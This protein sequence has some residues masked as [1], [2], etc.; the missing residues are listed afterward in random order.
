MTHLENLESIRGSDVLN[1]FM[2][3]DKMGAE[4]STNGEMKNA[5]KILVVKPEGKVEVG[6]KG[7][8]WIHLAQD[9]ER[10]RALVNTII[11]FRVS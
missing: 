4:Y 7:V 1:A 11:N 6:G 3:E 5:F 9:R 2:E 10:W 8:D